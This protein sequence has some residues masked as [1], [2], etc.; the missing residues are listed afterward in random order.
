MPYPGGVPE[1]QAAVK[2]RTV[3]SAKAMKILDRLD[4]KIDQRI[5]GKTR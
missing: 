4:R 5:L 2:Y 1:R 3:L